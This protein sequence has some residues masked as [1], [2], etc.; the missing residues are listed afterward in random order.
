MW[1][2][3]L[4]LRQG[5][6]GESIFKTSSINIKGKHEKDAQFCHYVYAF[7]WEAWTFSEGKHER[8]IK[9][10]KDSLDTGCSVSL[11]YFR[12]YFS[13]TNHRHRQERDNL[14]PSIDSKAG[15]LAWLEQG[16]KWKE[17]IK[18]VNFL[19][20]GALMR[21][22]R[23]RQRKTNTNEDLCLIG[24]YNWIWSTHVSAGRSL[25]IWLV[26]HRR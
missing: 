22:K 25:R 13:N 18:F 21:L 17:C 11:T 9:F 16:Q 1:H 2:T 20:T 23:P 12:L 26:S 15:N 5:Y 19:I 6:A 10:D 24:K 7:E 14:C 3:N 4:C 8:T